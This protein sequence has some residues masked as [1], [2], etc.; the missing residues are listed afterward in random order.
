M[1]NTRIEYFMNVML[2]FAW[3][4]EKNFSISTQRVFDKIICFF[5]LIF[6]TKKF[7]KN[8]HFNLENNRK[9]QN[10]SNIDKKNGF[11]I[12]KAM[13]WF[14]YLSSSI[15]GF[16]TFIV[17]G[18]VLRIFNEITPFGILILSAIPIALTCILDHAYLY[19]HDKY[20]E[21]FKQFEKEDEKWH[22]KWY[23][24]SIIFYIGC[25]M[26]YIVGGFIILAIAIL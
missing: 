2:Y 4:H 21:Y 7:R 14:G 1:N 24:I 9:L 26:L 25:I 23:S 15:P 12:T 3:L 17:L 19:S 6:F 16:F 10:K 8:F 18:F 11:Y 20:I 22:K 5:S 13:Y